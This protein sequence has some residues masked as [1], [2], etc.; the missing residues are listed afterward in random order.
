MNSKK[1][2]VL[3]ITSDQQH[4]YSMGFLNPEVNTPNLD[5]LAKMGT[6]FDRAYTVNPTCTPTRASL[7]T[8]MYPSQHGAYSLGTKLMESVPTVGDSFLVGFL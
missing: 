7:I 2:N 1:T 3:F 4:W 6:Y 8:G 5:R